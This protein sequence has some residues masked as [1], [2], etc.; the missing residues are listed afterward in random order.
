MKIQEAAG[1]LRPMERP[2]SGASPGK[3][4]NTN[5][6]RSQ[7]DRVSL[8]AEAKRFEAERGNRAETREER[9]QRLEELRRQVQSGSYK[10]DI[11]DVAMSLIR[12]EA[13][14]FS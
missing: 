6:A 10:P 9:N 8:S 7:G 13:T 12:D 1:K 5:L 4:E 3:R 11:R 2:R 14:P